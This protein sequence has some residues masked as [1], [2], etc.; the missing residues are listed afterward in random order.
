MFHSFDSRRSPEGSAVSLPTTSRKVNRSCQECTRRKVKCDSGYPC[1][2]LLAL[3]PRESLFILRS[4]VPQA[5]P[6]LTSILV[7]DEDNNNNGYDDSQ[8]AALSSSDDINAISLYRRSYLGVISISAVLRVIFRLCLATKKRY[9]DFYFNYIYLVI[10]IFNKD[11]FRYNLA[12]GTRLNSS[13]LALLN[14]VYTLGSIASGTRT[15]LDLDSLGSEPARSR[16]KN[17][18]EYSNYLLCAETRRRTWW[19]LF[20]LDTWASMTLGRPMYGRWDS[21]TLL[22]TL[23]FPNDYVVVSLRISYLF[24]YISFNRELVEWYDYLP[25]FL[26][27]LANSLL[28]LIEAREFMRN[29][30]LN[31]R[32][33]LIQ[34]FL[35]YLTYD[36]SLRRGANAISNVPGPTPNELALNSAWYLFQACMVPILSIAIDTHVRNS[37]RKQQQQEQSQYPPPPSTMPTAATI[38]SPEHNIF[39]PS[40]CAS[41]TKALELFNDMRSWMRDSDRTPDIVGALYEAVTTD[42]EG[43]GAGSAIRTPSTENSIDMSM[44]CDEQL[45]EMDWSA[46]LGGGDGDG[47]G[48]VDGMHNNNMFVFT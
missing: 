48:G 30:Y 16:A 37:V 46:F 38:N 43:S 34:S 10:P 31:V 13:W 47:S 25:N 4:S 45:V 32:L 42:L 6:L 1:A 21:N 41:L 8:P 3:L 29:R 40:W 28:C 2:K 39:L 9:I 44:W 20:C 33:I 11:N 27:N 15:Y 24:C 14:I 18:T 17:V 19:S 22:P 26:K 12:L 36:Y 5:D 23:L 7:A 35:L